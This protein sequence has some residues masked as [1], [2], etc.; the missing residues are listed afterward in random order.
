MRPG[1]LGASLSAEVG[2][3]AA[4]SRVRELTLGRCRRPTFRGLETGVVQRR[5]RGLKPHLLRNA[6]SL[7]EKRPGCKENGRTESFIGGLG[8]GH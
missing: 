3:D 5:P 4:E 6:F 8:S 7:R 2:R 1:G